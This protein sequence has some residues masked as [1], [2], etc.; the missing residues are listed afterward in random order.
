MSAAV[1]FTNW[2]DEEFIHTWDGVPYTFPPKAQMYLQDHL[3]I[4]FSKHLTIREM[5][6]LGESWIEKDN[7]FTSMM[8]KCI[9]GNASIKAENDEQLETKLLNETVKKKAG[10][11]KNEEVKEE[12][13]F[14]GLEDE[15]TV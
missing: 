9:S 12:E 15:T 11:P 7:R 4:H 14:E 3:A 10:R 5:N 13:I 6:K 1:L 8:E 2:T